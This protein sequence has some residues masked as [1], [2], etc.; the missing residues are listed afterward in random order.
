MCLKTQVCKCFGKEASKVFTFP[1]SLQSF[2]FVSKKSRLRCFFA[3]NF[4]LNLSG[5]LVYREPT[6][7]ISRDSDQPGFSRNTSPTR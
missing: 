6:Y 1:G 4:I 7:C 3:E 2:T 5:V